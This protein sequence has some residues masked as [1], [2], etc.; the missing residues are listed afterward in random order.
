MKCQG[1]FQASYWEQLRFA[2]ACFPR[3]LLDSSVRSVMGAACVWSRKGEAMRGERM[4]GTH[5]GLCCCRAIINRRRTPRASSSPSQTQPTNQPAAHRK[6]EDADR[7]LAGR[8]DQL[9]CD[10][11]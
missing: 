6:Q 9:D 8:G 11:A 2:L 5:A 7:L 10:Q 3:L 4:S 1:A